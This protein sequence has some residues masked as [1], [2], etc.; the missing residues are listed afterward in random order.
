MGTVATTAF[1]ILVL[2]ESIF[3]C[4]QMQSKAKAKMCN[5]RRHVPLCSK[6]DFRTRAASDLDLRPFV[7]KN[8]L[9]ISP[10][11]GNFFSRYGMVW[12][13]RVYRP[14]RHTIGQFGDFLN[15][16][17]FS[18]LSASLYVSK[19]GAY[20]DRLCRDV[21]GRWLVGWL[22]CCHARALCGQTVHPRL[23]V[24]MEH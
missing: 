8:P 9:P 2:H 13:S 5:G 22:V 16:V 7:L 1:L 18:V 4:E 14:N 17:W 23:I 21:V 19:R 11:V 15:F 24:T 20:W 12:Y 10:D 6:K 3:F